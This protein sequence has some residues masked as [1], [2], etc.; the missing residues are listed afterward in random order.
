PALE[1]EVERAW[2]DAAHHLEVAR[3]LGEEPPGRE[4]LFLEPAAWRAGLARLARPR[5][6]RPA[7]GDPV[8]QRGAARAARGAARERPGDAGRGRAG[9]RLRAADAA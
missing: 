8:R 1:R 2:V 5:G 7:D 6:G 3:R 4:A 9:R